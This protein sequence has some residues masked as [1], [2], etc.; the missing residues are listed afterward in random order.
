M[1]C[2]IPSTP[3]KCQ[4]LFNSL[5]VVEAE[6][7]VYSVSERLL[8]EQPAHQCRSRRGCGLEE[9][10]SED[11]THLTSCHT[12]TFLENPFCCGMDINCLTDSL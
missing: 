10:G 9:G 6:S 1:A 11:T 12:E 2:K 5:E 3:R 8:L 7:E 4:K